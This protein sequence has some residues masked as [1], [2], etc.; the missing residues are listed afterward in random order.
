MTSVRS[1]VSGLRDPVS[2]RGEGWVFGMDLPC[3][4]ESAL[5]CDGI[6]TDLTHLIALHTCI[7]A[8]ESGL[9]IF[10]GLIW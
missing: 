6:G 2:L 9:E 8:F 4:F 7:G 5:V 10:H 1:E 3:A